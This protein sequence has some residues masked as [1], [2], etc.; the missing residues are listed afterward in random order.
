MV[1]NG[2]RSVQSCFRLDEDLGTTLSNWTLL[3][4]CSRFDDAWVRQ[5][6]FHEDQLG[7]NGG[8]RNSQVHPN[9]SYFTLRPDNVTPLLAAVPAILS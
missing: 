3:L 5:Q 2:V 8:N 9:N 7:F 1:R 6:V 4:T